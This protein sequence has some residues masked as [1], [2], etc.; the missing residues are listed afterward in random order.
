MDQAALTETLNSL[1]ATWENEVIEFKQASNDFQTS[2]IGQYFSALANE[3][4]L[5]GLGCGWLVFG[6]NNKTRT[7][8]GTDYREDIE[9]LNSLKQQI[10]DG[11]GPS[12]SFRN[13]H[14]LNH[15]DGRVVLMEVPA[16]PQGMP[17]AWNGHFHA[18]NGE[19][20]APL[21]LDKLDEIRAQTSQTDWTAQVVEG[22]T[23]DDLDP[24]A[25]ARA[26]DAFA[27]KHANRFD[28]DEV[29]QWTDAV[30]LDRARVTQ[31]GRVTRTALLLLG[32]AESAYL[33][34]PHKAELTW[35]LVGEETAYEHFG[36]PFL[37]NSTEL[38]RKI[39]NIQLRILPDNE[40]LAHEVSKYDQ[41]VVLE[42]L[43][44]CIAHQDYARNA[45]I[46][47]TEK[48]DR[49]ILENE[50]NFFEGAPDDYVGG[51]KTPRRYRNPFLV[52][53]MTELNMIDTMGFGIHRIF[54]A[55]RRRYFPMPDYDLSTDGVVSVV[56]HGGVVDTAY[57]R[58]LMENTDLALTD[59]LAIDR[60]Q[61]HL[62]I[63]DLTAKHLRRLRLIEGR[64]PNYRVSAAVAAATATRKEYIRNR[65]LDDRHYEE[66]IVEYLRKFSKA[67]RKD[68]DGLLWEKLSDSLDDAQRKHKI[69]NLLSA[70][71]GKGVIFNA[72]SR[73]A[74]E[75]R[76]QD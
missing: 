59:V 1:I 66:L 23:L 55:Q 50:G 63:P 25:V 7:V 57:S 35:K 43:H 37:L 67:S 65:P 4:N 18:R 38:F 45:R 40:L 52:Q 29:A 28:A 12:L 36:L 42:A 32:K 64:K 61:K 49:L 48:T 56:I 20:L 6:V 72:A 33:L 8:V 2:K 30:L 47:V 39:R 69:G 54:V 15:P 27:Q 51:H 60:V 22:A 31:G 53:A 10:A 68:I 14:V 71:R 74:P 58:L 62:P 11:T 3:A 19:S 76:I 24:A 70:L 73:T 21:A 44:N 41:K 75:W 13:I 17:I 46:V 26:R 9:R 5:Q 34:S 16:A